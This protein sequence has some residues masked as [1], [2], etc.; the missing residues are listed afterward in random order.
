VQPP[1]SAA[2]K[3]KIKRGLLRGVVEL[4]GDEAMV[5]V[6]ATGERVSSV[7]GV[8]VHGAGRAEQKSPC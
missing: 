2:K 3:I 6:L 5:T 4:L 8:I 1:F 7:L